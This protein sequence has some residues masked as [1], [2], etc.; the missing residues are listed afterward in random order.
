MN[1]THAHL[2]LMRHLTRPAR[3]G[4]AGVV[5]VFA[6]LYLVAAKAGLLGLPLAVI[7][8]SWF[9][10]YAYILLD[11]SARGFDEP[12]TLDIQMMNP[13]DE[14]RPLAQVAILGLIYVGV[15]FVE[16]HFGQAAATIV[17]IIAAFFL[18]ASIAVLGM[19]NN[20]LKAAFPLAWLHMI[21]GLGPLYALILLVIAGYGLAMG[22]VAR[23]DLW[24]PVEF[25]L[26]M[27]AMLSIFSFLGGALYERRF[28]LGVETWV[29]PE[30]TEDRAQKHKLHDSE[31][32]V[33]EAYGLMRASAHIKSWQLLADW[34]TSQGGTP[35]AYGW[36]CEHVASWDDPRYMTRL[37]EDR[38]HRLLTLK[39]NGEALDV[40]TQRL[41]VDQNFRPK[42]AADTFAI[43]QLAAR[44]GGIP[45]VARTL[46][47][48]F[49]I[50]FS[51]DPHVAPAGTLA[52]Q[53]GSNTP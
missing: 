19:E 22:V 53:L 12:P 39:R 24:M 47:A 11:H 13:L 16:S 27:F 37:S 38:V 43:A 49:A 8:T 3:G 50:R 45:R 10:K 6:L 25:A 32:I 4:A 1:S 17:T 34:L 26:G 14:Q 41:A 51:G 36:L 52:R 5:L 7:L 31:T 35:E 44:G 23:L 15:K 29:S 18:P 30:R 46:L 42:S 40:V 48:D 33:L 2:K 28:E 21:R 20:I 9:F